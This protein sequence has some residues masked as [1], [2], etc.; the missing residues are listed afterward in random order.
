[1]T[2]RRFL[3]YSQRI[4]SVL[5]CENVTKLILGDEPDYGNHFQD[6]S[7]GGNTAIPTNK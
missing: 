5:L 3:L 1:M 6:M 7:R 2:T 4:E